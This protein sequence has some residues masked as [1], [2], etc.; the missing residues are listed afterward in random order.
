MRHLVMGH[1][2]PPTHLRVT[3]RRAGA[4]TWYR[5]L[6]NRPL[7]MRWQLRC[8]RRKPAVLRLSTAHGVHPQGVRPRSNGCGRIPQ[9]ICPLTPP[10]HIHSGRHGP[11]HCVLCSL[12]G[13]PC[14]PP[15]RHFSASPWAAPATAA[16][17][18]NLAPG[19]SSRPRRLLALLLYRPPT[20][21]LWRGQLPT[22]WSFW[23]RPGRMPRAA[24]GMR[25]VPPQ[26]FR[27]FA[28][29]FSPAF[30]FSCSRLLRS[31]YG[32]GAPRL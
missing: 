2:S 26:V 21:P 14:S 17:G 15:R 25:V 32:G 22:D 30:V 3:S 10:R 24:A 27:G 19:D 4:R 9:R 20:M 16:C 12:T 31:W 8:A 13:E 18:A 7:H 28:I 5:K 29:P 11:A 1:G 23:R 6:R